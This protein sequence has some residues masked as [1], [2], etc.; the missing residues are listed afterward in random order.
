MFQG[1]SNLLVMALIIFFSAVSVAL[2]NGRR[3]IESSK[4]KTNIAQNNYNSGNQNIQSLIE[5][6][7]NKD[8]TKVKTLLDTGI[9]VTT[10]VHQDFTAMHFAAGFGNIETATILLDNGGDIDAENI[11][12][13]TPL[14]AAIV[15][16]N[17]DVAKFLIENGANVEHRVSGGFSPLHIAAELGRESIAKL[18][19]EKGA[20]VDK[21][22]NQGITPFHT[23]AVFGQLALA[24]LLISYGANINATSNDGRTAIQMA[25]SENNREIVELIEKNQTEDHNS[26]GLIGQMLVEING[27]HFYKNSGEVISISNEK[28]IIIMNLDIVT[29]LITSDTR[30][31]DDGEHMQSV[32]DICLGEYVTITSKPNE[33]FAIDVFKWQ[34]AT[35]IPQKFLNT[36]TL[37]N[38]S[39][40][41][42]LVKVVGSTTEIINVPSGLSKTVHVDSGEYYL[43]IRYGFNPD[44]FTYSRGESFN[45]EHSDTYYS[46]LFITLHKVINGNYSTHESSRMEFESIEFD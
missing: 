7:K 13:F 24:K 17:Y 40:E 46:E 1:K 22:N 16:D 36:I 18:L 10:K 8:I 26:F 42:A 28:I 11:K 5:A 43:L 3:L 32:N 30:I 20:F 38:Y 37:E 6:I 25:R 15:T 44:Q 19:I 2:P 45:I 35:P 27:E 31:S 4:V 21:K 34:E 23:A 9:D 39:G 14:C 41:F 12:G 29:F 33:N